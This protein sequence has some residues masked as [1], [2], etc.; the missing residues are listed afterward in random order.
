MPP[1]EDPDCPAAPLENRQSTIAELM[2]TD[3]DPDPPDRAKQTRSPSANVVWLV[4]SLNSPVVEAVIVAAGFAS[5]PALRSLSVSELVWALAA[6]RTLMFRVV[7]APLILTW[8]NDSV[9]PPTELKV[10]PG[11]Q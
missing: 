4:R 5:A 10:D 6:T 9:V 11:P 2:L 8:A 1:P 3:P 7:C